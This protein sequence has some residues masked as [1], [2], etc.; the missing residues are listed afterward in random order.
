[1][2]Y[3]PGNNR[4]KFANDFEV[5]PPP[6]G[7]STFGLKMKQESVE[8]EFN[9]FSK[10]LYIFKNS[11]HVHALIKDLHVDLEIE[12][13]TQ[14]G[15]NKELAPKVNINKI[16][17]NVDKKHTEIKIS[18]GVIQYM[19]NLFESMFQR[20]LISYILKEVQKELKTTILDNLNKEA[21]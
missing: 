10:L 5:V 13:A 11:G 16:D 19:F 18:G 20:Y 6:P 8:L 12:L 7:S 21:L 3:L 17:I 1:M 4:W 9:Y 2:L 15:A 14:D